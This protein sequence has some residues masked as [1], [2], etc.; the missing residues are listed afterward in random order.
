MPKLGEYLSRR[1]ENDRLARE[2]IE[3]AE[4]V[5]RILLGEDDEGDD[6]ND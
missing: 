1:A 3:E 5:A 2:Q 6:N 4:D